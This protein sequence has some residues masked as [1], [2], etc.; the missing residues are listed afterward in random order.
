MNAVYRFAAL[1]AP[2]V[3][4]ALTA[5]PARAEW[6]ERPIKLVVPYA[7]GSGADAAIRPVA[8]A[9]GKELR[10]PVLIDN[11]S[12]GSGIIGTQALVSAAPDGYTIGYGNIATLAINRSYFSKLPYDPVKQIELVGQI[13]SNAYVLIARK[14]LPASNLQ[15]MLAYARKNAG[16]VTIGS[17][18]T[19]GAA[20]LAAE[21]LQ[22]QTGTSLVHVPYKTGTQGATDMINGQLDLMLDNISAVLPYVRDGRVKA[23]AVTGLQR[24]GVL[25]DVPTVDESGVKGF[26]LVAWAGLIVPTGTPKPIVH[27][28]N[29]ALAKV[30]DDPAVVRARAAMSIDAVS[31]TPEEFAALVR[32]ETARWADVVK[33]TG[34]KG[35]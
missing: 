29:A 23:L 10:Q 32:R 22:I 25:P 2:L 17:P 6:P 3:A 16:K 9:L 12:G 11:R 30:S 19:G 27:K 35:D 26:E 14:D 18:G 4:L 28:L 1:A 24:A 20:H 13:G 5:A 31:S 7:A 34:I 15:E 21:Q 33:R 8:D